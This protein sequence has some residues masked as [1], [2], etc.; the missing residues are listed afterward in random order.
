[1][2]SRKF[3]LVCWSKNY[4][5]VDNLVKLKQN[6]K[7]NWWQG[8][9]VTKP[10]LFSTCSNYHQLKPNLQIWHKAKYK[11]RELKKWILSKHQEIPKVGHK[12]ID[13]Q[14]ISMINLIFM[15]KEQIVKEALLRIIGNNHIIKT[16]YI[17]P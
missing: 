8:H 12:H 11:K 1:M 10:L 9:T 4:Q 15:E 6:S 14:I 13:G 3:Q 7:A 5:L 2:C 17:I 16:D